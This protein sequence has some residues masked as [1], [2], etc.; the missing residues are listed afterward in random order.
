MDLANQDWQCY[1]N[2]DTGEIVTV[3]DEDRASL[4]QDAD[5][6]DLPDWEREAVTKTREAL[7]SNRFLLLPGSF[8]VHE[9]AIMERFAQER[10]IAGQRDELL[11]SLHGRGAFRTFKSA[12][13]RLRIEKSGTTFVIWRWRRLPKTGWSQTGSSTSRVE[14]QRVLVVAV[15]HKLR[16]PGYWR[17]RIPA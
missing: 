1:L 9:W 2:R 12:I 3:T 11:D 4:E 16:R 5:L 13:R 6:D 8:E 15:A 7:E 10:R 17:S 14:P